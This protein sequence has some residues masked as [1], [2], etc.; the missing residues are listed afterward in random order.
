MN[1]NRKINENKLGKLVTTN[2]ML[3]EKYGDH[4]TM[5]RNVFNTKSMEYINQF[6][7]EW[8]ESTRQSI[9]SWSKQPASPEEVRRQQERLNL[10]RT[11]REGKFVVDEELCEVPKQTIGKRV[12]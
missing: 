4:G 6:H 11:I 3:N 2:E 8:I 12:L 10:Q 9:A 5:S 1:E 7:M